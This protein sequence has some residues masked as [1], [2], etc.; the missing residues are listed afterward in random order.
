MGPALVSIVEN[1]VIAACIVAFSR[2]G[3]GV[4]C[5]AGAVVTSHASVIYGNPGG[6]WVGCLAGQESLEHNAHV[7]PLFCGLGGA[8]FYLCEN[9]YCAPAGNPLSIQIGALG[10][11]CDPCDSPVETLSWG[12]IKALYR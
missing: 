5:E 10:P 11:G 4:S 6:D 12:A 8:W 3:E 2:T 1:S 9:S 7:D